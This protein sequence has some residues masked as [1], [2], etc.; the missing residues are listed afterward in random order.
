[1]NF[2]K[3]IKRLNKICFIKYKLV[4]IIFLLIN[5]PNC[6]FAR[7]NEEERLLTGIVVKE[8][9]S[10]AIENVHVINL[11]QV[12]GTS[13][14]QDGSFTINI[15]EGDSIMFQAVGYENDTIYV[16]ED[17]YREKDHVVVEL[18]TRTYTLPGVDVFPYS[19]Y[20]EFKQAFI[21]FDDDKIKDT[22][23]SIDL[24]LPERLYIDPTSS[25]GLGITMPGPFTLI[26][27][28]FSQSGRE[29]R[30]Y[31]EVKAEAERQEEISRVVNPEVVRG[32]TSLEDEEE[33]YDFL[34]YCN[35]S[36]E[37]IVNSKEYQV[38]QTILSCYRQY[39]NKR[40]QLDRW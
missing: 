18:L 37:F 8:E 6:L 24:D 2:R 39:K 21:H 19:T 33:I 16:T 3:N 40:R 34:D 11:T 10:T 35:M 32:L 20:S 36:Y 14:T 27:E 17:F 13:T 26:Y 38:Y 1:M 23:P 25:E 15:M 31:R 9:D 12:L 29:R 7:E 28:Q 5:L 30:K 4:I 22:V